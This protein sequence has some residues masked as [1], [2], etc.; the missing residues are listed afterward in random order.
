MPGRLEKLEIRPSRVTEPT[1]SSWGLVAKFHFTSS[2]WVIP[3]FP[4]ASTKRAFWAEADTSGREKTSFQP[5]GST[6]PGTPRDMLMT[7]ALLV[8]SILMPE[9]MSSQP[10]VPVSSKGL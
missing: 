8:A 6:D 4:A 9:A 3:W 2:T 1:T 7:L 5:A 10:A